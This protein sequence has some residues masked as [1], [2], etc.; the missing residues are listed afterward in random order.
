[1]IRGIVYAR[2]MNV[3]MRPFRPGLDIESMIDLAVSFP[4]D[5]PH[6]VD[7]PYHLCSWALDDPSN[8]A[9][10]VDERGDMVAWAVLQFPFWTVDIV[11][12]PNTEAELFPIALEWVIARGR[13]AL[14]TPSARP[15]WYVH[16]FADQ[17]DRLRDLENAGFECQADVGEDSWSRILLQHRGVMPAPALLAAGFTIRPLA[18]AREAEKYVDL[19]RAAFGSENM[20]AEWRTRML[21]APHHHPG[22][23]LVAVAEDGQLVGFCIGWLQPGEESVGQIEPMGVASEFRGKGLGAA[24]L[25]ECLSRLIGLGA[26]TAFVETDTFRNPALQLY[27]S[28]GFRSNRDILV[29][30]KDFADE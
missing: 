11:I 3:R 22:T 15:S 17:S 16:L 10:W 8:V 24:L 25:A 19:H 1:M 2:Q 5:N 20:T 14:G 12:H 28:L 27:R 30:R 6:V 26:T 4:H 18:G 9:L 21:A 13:A 29:C 23:D 7:L